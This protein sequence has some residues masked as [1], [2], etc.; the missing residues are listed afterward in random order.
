M[1][2]NYEEMSFELNDSYRALLIM[3]IALLIS[4]STYAQDTVKG[5]VTSSDDG[6]GL[7]GVSV[8]IKGSSTGAITDIDG[9]YSLKANSADVLVFT[10]IGMKLVERPVDAS[11]IDVVLDP[12][13]KMLEEVVKIGYGE[14]KKKEVTG[15]V[16]SVKSEDITRVVTSD[17][18]SAIQGQ[19]AG[20]NVTASGAPGENS[21]ILIRGISSLQG[22]NTPLY[23]VDGVP[24]NGD[25]GLSPNEIE[26]ID[27]LKDA[28][29]AAIYGTR[30]SAG[31]ILITT[32]QGEEGS[33]RISVNGSY[34]VQKITSGVP[35]LNA[36]EQSYVDLVSQRE[37]AG[38]TDNQIT[39]DLRRSPKGFTNDTKLEDL[40]IVDHASVQD[41]NANISGGKGDVVYNVTLGYFNKEGSIINSEF[42]RFNS[43]I[44]TTYK[45]KKWR[46]NANLGITLE[47]QLSAPGGV[48]GQTIRYK[49]TNDAPDSDNITVPGTGGITRQNWV[50]ESISNTDE[51]KRV[52]TYMNYNVDYSIIDNL[53]LSSRLGLSTTNQYRLRFDPYQEF[54]NAFDGEVLSDR[55]RDSGITND[56]INFFSYTWDARLNYTKRVN[57]HKFNAIA[58]Y[59]VEQ[60]EQDAF[61]ANKTGVANNNIKAISQ[62]VGNPE[63]TQPVLAYVN[64]LTGLLGRLQYDYDSK[65][66][67]SAS[68]RRDGSSRFASGNRF[69]VFPSLS[70]GWNVSEEGFWNTLSST[71]NNFKLRASYGTTGNQRIPDYSYSAGI[72]TGYDYLFGSAGSQTVALGSTQ[73]EYANGE[74]K[75]ETTVQK[76]IGADLGF[77][78]NKLSLNADFYISDKEDML[79]PYTL[80]GTV[81]TGRVGAG[82]GLRRTV[83][84]N[85]GDME[86]RGM[87]LAL[88][89][90][91]NFGGVK[92]STNA[93]FTTNRNKVKKVEQL[94]SRVPMNDGVLIPGTFSAVSQVTYLVPGY[95]AGAFMIFETDGIIDT[96]EKL[97]EYKKINVN[98]KKGDLIYVDQN[99][100]YVIDEDDRVYKG[101]GLPDYEIGFNFNLEYKGFDFFM[102]WYASVGHE[103][104]NGAK[105]N[106]YGYGRH[107]DLVSMYSLG[108]QTSTVPTYRQQGDKH[109]NYAG[110]TDLW[111]EDGSY[112]RLRT[113][114]L[115]Y[116]LPNRITDKVGVKKTRLY[117]SAQNPITI[118][119]YE[120]YDP[121]IGGGISTRGLDRG[122]YPVTAL[123]LVGLQLNL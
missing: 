20:V 101:S 60:F 77:F 32:K 10:F 35:L 38:S 116:T 120:G 90:R 123:Y 41:Y 33:M 31:V 70:V 37:E 57:Q 66:I 11:V 68:V 65:Y 114:T 45:T 79:F 110:D 16:A 93:T 105:A 78:A 43:R 88:S 108:N 53:T 28:A 106:A 3:F 44:N 18:G 83:W 59:S 82:N 22:N 52:K 122:N 112:L 54:V 117:V 95:E 75:W 17:L 89:Y 2:K 71:V 48:I 87:E 36:Q 5:I 73:A 8:R 1:K 109:P 96:D 26:S 81:G 21:Q 92:F 107:K 29:S 94:G 84:L 49:P 19:I 12:D 23:V 61:Q 40:I 99:G 80:P 100:D 98:A 47:N 42:E 118:T 76:N 91:D 30:G 102:Q 97:A 58:V 39:L 51:N 50:L 13:T 46:V 119:K 7:P 14:Q 27:V 6:Y 69:G 103:I 121:E 62:A 55:N 64:K 67:L 72:V 85:V 34:G 56:A 113:V 15:A 115:G 63:V 24:Q 9:K 86:N 25:P 104:M 4:F 111:L 74:V